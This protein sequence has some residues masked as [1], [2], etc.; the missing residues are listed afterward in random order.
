MA[1]Q[2]GGIEPLLDGFF[3]FLRRKTDFFT[4]ASSADAAQASVLAAFTKNK[5]RSEEDVRERTAKEKKRKAEEAARKERLAAEK[6]KQQKAKEK[7]E[8]SRIVD[9]TDEPKAAASSSK[10]AAPGEAAT[11]EV[12]AKEGDDGEGESKGQTPVNNGGTCDNYRWEQTL[13]DLTVYVAVPKG[14]KAKLIDVTIAKKKLRVAVAGH[15][16]PLIDGELLQAVKMED[17]SW[18]VE[19][20]PADD[21]RLVTITLTKVNGM[22]WC[23]R[24]VP[25]AW[26]PLVLRRHGFW[27]WHMQDAC[28]HHGATRRSTES[29]AHVT[30]TLGALH[31]AAGGRASL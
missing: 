15:P 16:A 11:D 8:E 10:E 13:G 1:G 29:I 30:P 4:G 2:L 7:E 5:E 12:G 19:D 25:P 21:N 18:S 28:S 9:V 20:N 14:T 27:Q 22:E 6:A 31:L 23:A 26:C 17:S 3:G 24:H